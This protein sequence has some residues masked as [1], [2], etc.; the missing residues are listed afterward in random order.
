MSKTQS[1]R[2]L[3]PLA[4]VIGENEGERRPGK[5]R[6]GWMDREGERKREI[7][8]IFAIPFIAT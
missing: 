4:V 3:A 7:D 6:D 5:M 1:F 8:N 2:I